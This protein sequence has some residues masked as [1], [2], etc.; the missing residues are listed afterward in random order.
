MQLSPSPTVASLTVPRQLA[1]WFCRSIAVG[2][3][4]VSLGG[5][6]GPKTEVVPDAEVNKAQ[7]DT[8]EKYA[9]ATLSSWAEDK[10]PEPPETLSPGMRQA[11]SPA[12]QKS[13]DKALEAEIGDFKS[14][15][16]VEAVR[17][18]PA[19]F[20]LYRFKGTFSKGAQPLEVRVVFDTDGKISGF[21]VRPWKDKI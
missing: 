18:V 21:W 10:Y 9:Q 11:N 19:Q 15:T 8:A 13:A 6:T 3:L 4:A 16:Y 1:K 7:K 2:A 5:C 17:S 20:V 12:S 14:M